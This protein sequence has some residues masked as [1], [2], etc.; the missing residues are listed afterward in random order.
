MRLPVR[1]PPA[2]GTP[3]RSPMALGDRPTRPH[4]A[5][6]PLRF[7]QNAHPDLAD[8]GVHRAV[9]VVDD[10]V[11]RIRD[12]IRRMSGDVFP[13]RCAVDLAPRSTLAPRESFRT[14]EY[15]IRHRHRCLH[16]R[17]ITAGQAL[18]D[19]PHLA[20]RVSRPTG[21]ARPRTRSMRRPSTRSPSARRP[22]C[23]NSSV[24]QVRSPRIVA[25][26]SLPESRST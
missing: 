13:K 6:S 26:G 16:T 22:L 5:R 18:A 4:P 21:Y 11:D 14:L 15:V 23:S 19:A 10:P 24:S 25:A 17:S 8:E 1:P 7:L 9:D 3:A 12:L 2:G 20:H